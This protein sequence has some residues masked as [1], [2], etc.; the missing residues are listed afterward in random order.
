MLFIKSMP[1]GIQIATINEHYNI[2][3][4]VRLIGS[5]VYII[6]PLRAPRA[7]VGQP[8]SSQELQEQPL[9]SQEP[10]RGQFSK[11]DR[12]TIQTAADIPKKLKKTSHES[13]VRLSSINYSSQ[14][15]LFGI[16]SEICRILRIH[17]E[18]VP[19]L[20]L[21]PPHSTRTGGQDDG[22]LH[23]LPQII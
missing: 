15:E 1:G 13:S 23:K 4:A 5:F 8:K 6:E 17:A 14:I 19:E 22:S 10:P 20:R 21:G 3:A 2:T 12:K 18:V 7:A 16:R 11:F 9:A